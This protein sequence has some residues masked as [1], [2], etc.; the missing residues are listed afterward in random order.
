MV[1]FFRAWLTSVSMTIS[2]SVYVS[3]SGIILFFLWLSNTPLHICTTFSL[4]IPCWW[5]F[6]FLPCRAI[7]DS[8][9]VSTEVYVFFWIMV[10]SSYI[11]RSGIERSCCNSIFSFFLRS[12]FLKSLLNLLQDCFFMFWFF[13]HENCG[14]LAAQPR[15]KLHPLP[16]KAVLPTGPP[17]KSLFLVFKGIWIVFSIVTVPIYSTNSVG[18]FYRFFK[19]L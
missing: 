16:Y 19:T 17:R 7:V 6:G 10:F 13:G 3:A 1:L 18:G 14:I 8:A 11:L 5:M 2:R 12:F 4:H 15:S 9:P